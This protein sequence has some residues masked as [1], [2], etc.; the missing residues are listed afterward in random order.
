VAARGATAEKAGA[1]RMA[2]RAARGATVTTVNG[3][4]MVE[5]VAVPVAEASEDLEVRVAMVE[6][7]SFALETWP[8]AAWP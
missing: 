6:P 5:T 8:M 4:A 1:G 7:L 3:D 2:E